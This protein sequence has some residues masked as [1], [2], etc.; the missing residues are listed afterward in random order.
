MEVVEIAKKYI[1]I[2]EKPS[3]SG[4]NDEA[5][6]K[7]MEEVGWEKGQAYCSYFT[8]MVFKEADQKSWWKLEK[9][10]HGSSVQTYKNFKAA[11]YKIYDKPFQGAL[12]IYQ[13]YVNGKPDWRGHSAICTG[14]I[15]EQYYRTIDANT[16]KDNEVGD[17]REGYVVAPKK[18]KLKPNA[19]N[20]LREIAF[21]KVI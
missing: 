3:N 15:D 8:E 16:V 10:F 1:G 13:R 18:K 21:I 2:V 9:L 5:F 12:V 19:L 20:G 11:G 6:Q 7:K 4:W 17:V 14:V